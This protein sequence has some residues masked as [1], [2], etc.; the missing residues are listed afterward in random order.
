M[1]PCMRWPRDAASERDGGSATILALACLAALAVATAVVVEI[2]LS[3][4]ARHH[5]AA[6]ADTTSLAAAAMVDAGPGTACD[7]AR[8]VARRNG[9]TVTGCHVTGPVVT[10]QVS[11]RLGWPLAWLRP[12]RLNSRAGPAETNTDHPGQAA[13]AS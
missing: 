3:V 7:E 11:L 13:A 5:L 9:V 12:L 6:V 1:K 10:V 8:T 2:G 4:A